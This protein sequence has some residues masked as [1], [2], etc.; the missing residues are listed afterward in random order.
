M[1]VPP[2]PVFS[3][4]PRRGER[5]LPVPTVRA[6]HPLDRPRGHISRLIIAASAHFCN[7][8]GNF[9]VLFNFLRHFIAK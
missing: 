2:I 6:H 9:Y 4:L 5:S 1:T 8:L 7:F 3:L